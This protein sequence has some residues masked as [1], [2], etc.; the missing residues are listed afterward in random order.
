MLAE[1]FIG[2]VLD[3]IGHE[4]ARDVATAWASERLAVGS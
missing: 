3:R 1:A 4:G 2:E